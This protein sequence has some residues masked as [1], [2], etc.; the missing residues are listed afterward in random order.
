[1]STSLLLIDSVEETTSLCEHDGGPNHPAAP[2]PLLP[3]RPSGPSG[4]AEDCRML[5]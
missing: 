4:F 5:G 2:T 1:M 3:T